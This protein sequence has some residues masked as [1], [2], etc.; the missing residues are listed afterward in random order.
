MSRLHRTISARLFAAGLAALVAATV[1]A[2]SVTRG[3]YLQMGT[4]NSVVVRWR[5]DVATESRLSYGTVLGNFTSVADNPAVATEHEVNLSG[6]T[7]DS[8]YYYAVGTTAEI[9]AG[10]D[11]TY[12]FLTAPPVG[13]PKPTRIWVLGDSGT[14]N[15]NAQAV[16]DA[17]YTFTGPRHTDL[18]LMLG[19][20]AY[21][22]GTDREYQ[23]AVFN[24]Y[25]TMLRKSVLWPTLGNHDGHSANSGAQSGPYYNI[26]TLPRN[27][28]AGGLAS[29][30]E[31]YYSFDYGNIH[32]IVLDSSETDRSPGGAMMTWLTDDLLA[33]S[34][35][36][37][38][39]YWHH[40]P[41]TKGSHNSNGEKE[42]VKMRRYA[43]PI[44]EDL[45]VDLVLAGHSHSYE[46]SFL[47]DGHYGTS[48]T[49]APS[50]ILNNGDGRPAGN[51]A[52]EKPTA[53]PIPNEGTVYTVMGSS[54]RT[55]GGRLNHP[56]MFTS[57]N[58]LGSLVLDVDGNRL[59][60]AFLDSTGT[61]R[62]TFTILK[63]VGGKNSSGDGR[64]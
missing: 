39:A 32:F 33:T 52:Y 20:N 19:D 27:A 40:P 56:A 57:L 7:A 4:P 46:R 17:Y 23:R 48:R 15:A 28:E 49:L 47:L 50:M 30:T 44:L 6:L 18:W 54:G 2:A 11:A 31:A 61:V 34:Q 1:E 25:P 16:R 51:G 5:T 22:D 21:G 60:A 53:G 38:I 13:V 26:F 63:G 35:D 37:I 29:G 12:F 45:G 58:V 24:T 42:P 36:W 64:E 8:I 41:Y 9:L 62:D 59:D 43:L 3:P 14:A 10:N 55:S